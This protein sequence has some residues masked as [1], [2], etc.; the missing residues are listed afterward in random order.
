MNVILA[1]LALAILIAL[2]GWLA[3]KAVNRV[4]LTRR[5]RQGL[6]IEKFRAGTPAVLLFTSSDCRPCK[7]IQRPALL[8]LASALEGDL[9]VIEIDVY[10]R[11]ELR[12][13]WGVLSLPTT[14][15]I[16]SF[17]RPRHVNHGVAR[18]PKLLDQLAHIGELPADF[19]RLSVEGLAVEA[20]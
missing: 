3:Y 2:I 4:I 8:R 20:D 13:R 6:G 1:R 10:E 7:A 11:P 9:Q 12:D 5:A 14:F 18:E 16:D 19:K 15:V 17:G